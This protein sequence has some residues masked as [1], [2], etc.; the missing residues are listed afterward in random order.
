[1]S[2]ADYDNDGDPDIYVVNDK[3]VHPIGNVLWR[4]DGEGCGGWCWTDASSETRTNYVRNGMGLAVGDYD[5]D[6]DLDFYFSDMGEPMSL[7]ENLGEHFR[8]ATETAGVGTEVGNTVG[9]GTAFF[10]YNN[11]GWQDLFLATTG[12]ADRFEN[13][14][15]AAGFCY[16]TQVCSLRIRATALSVT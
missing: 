7:L 1:M 14:T 3:V 2:F 15:G 16:R 8:N 9:W 4:N 5:N 10:D 6:L 11:D 12:A 13:P